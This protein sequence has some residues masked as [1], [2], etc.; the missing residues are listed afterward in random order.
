MQKKAIKC[1]LVNKKQIYLQNADLFNLFRCHEVVVGASFDNEFVVHFW[2]HLLLEGT[3]RPHPD[4]RTYRVRHAL[5]HHLTQLLRTWKT[6]FNLATTHHAGH[7]TL[8]DNISITNSRRSNI[9]SNWW[10]TH[11]RKCAISDLLVKKWMDQTF[12]VS[13]TN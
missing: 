1:N 10:W 7:V 5:V 2:L 3:G 6:T 8:A 11:D 4:L 9:Y 13:C 12:I